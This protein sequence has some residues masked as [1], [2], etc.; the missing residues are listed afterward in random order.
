MKK[1]YGFNCSLFL[2]PLLLLSVLYG[3]G[4]DSNVAEE[5]EEK[6]DRPKQE[7]PPYEDPVFNEGDS[8]VLFNKIEITEA[9]RILKG[10][11]DVFSSGGGF[12]WDEE[13]RDCYKEY[14]VPDTLRSI[15][16]GDTIDFIITQWTKTERGIELHFVD[17]DQISL[18]QYIRNDTLITS[19]GLDGTSSVAGSCAVRVKE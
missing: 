9:Q 8:V 2:I 6:P 4:K 19:N 1:E 3:C 18:L 12:N 5:P 11:W 14:I 17:S 10:K 16:R 13:V 7:L 15:N